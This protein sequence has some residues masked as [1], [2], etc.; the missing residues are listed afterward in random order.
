MFFS[1]Q[2][3]P[4]KKF[5]YIFWLA[6][7]LAL[8][9][10]GASMFSALIDW[11]RYKP[12]IASKI[13]EK[14]GREVAINGDISG[15][16]FPITEIT[17]L[18]ISVAGEKGGKYPNLA[19]IRK[20][21]ISLMPMALLS[22]DI[23]I[24]K[25]HFTGAQIFLE[26]FSSNKNNWSMPGNAPDAASSPD[27]G[28][29]SAFSLDD[30]SMTESGLAYF[31]HAEK[32]EQILS[33]IDAKASVDLGGP[34]LSL[35]G[36]AS[37]GGQ[38]LSF[39]LDAETKG[40]IAKT[41]LA[42]SGG[43]I[44]VSF[45]GAMENAKSL[46]SAKIKAQG[47]FSL[48]YDKAKLTAKG[49]LQYAGGVAQVKNLDIALGS[50]SGQGDVQV[51]IADAPEIKAKLALG[52]L[53]VKSLMADISGIAPQQPADPKAAP[54]SKS[55]FA[56]KGVVQLAI[57]E[58]SYAPY[59]AAPVT[60]NFSTN[61]GN[62]IMVQRFEAQ[63]PGDSVLESSGDYT[64]AAQQYNGKLNFRTRNLQQLTREAGISLAWLDKQPSS[65]EFESGIVY[66]PQKLQ[67]SEYRLIHGDGKANGDLS[68]SLGQN[69]GFD[70][71]IDFKHPNI[72]TLSGQPQLPVESA[73]N[74]SADLSGLMASNALDWKSLQGTA[75]TEL[76]GGKLHGVDL[77]QISQRLKE[78]NKV[79]DFLDLLQKARAQG[80][81]SF[82]KI[83]A[84]WTVV[85]G[86]AQSDNIVLISPP[87]NGKGK[88]RIDLAQ[89]DMNIATYVSFNEHPKAPPLG[90]LLSGQLT[91]PKYGFDSAA[92]QSYLATKA[93]NKVIE[94]NVDKE[95]LQQKI[96]KKID[97]GAQKLMNKLFGQ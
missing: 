40:N 8:A 11:D 75:K 27:G 73:V 12:L 80:Q 53:D 91:Q 95:K 25:L 96:D 85:K 10:A 19:L 16:I 67:L 68:L 64:M 92:V 39:S 48:K 23:Q 18:D 35:K 56:W 81:T 71:K 41:T 43:G 58:I 90:I 36:D 9:F 3:P 61:D 88:G 69:K 78:L 93:I 74:F 83:S 49:N 7:L 2:K 1:S 21:E 13:S 70:W 52:A 51:K 14:I 37:W 84:D 31:D 32:K 29:L 87:A 28:G 62:R 57:K 22:G 24:K 89:Q 44:D 20:L 65:A 55:A 34:D 33:D 30:L 60:L 46:D 38:P 50:A 82:D 5:N 79:N 76:P 66:T 42:F 63:L 45:D 94:K 97:E 86:V 59:R 54:A 26:K 6:L 47:P 77:V 17:A 4:R 15:T 72:R